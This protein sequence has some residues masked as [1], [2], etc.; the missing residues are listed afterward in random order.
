MAT[1]STT[2]LSVPSLGDEVSALAAEVEAH[3]LQKNS[4]W[5]PLLSKDWD[6]QKPSQPCISRIRRQVMTKVT[7]L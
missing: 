2:S 6:S 5:D 1:A 3:I 4:V 7:K